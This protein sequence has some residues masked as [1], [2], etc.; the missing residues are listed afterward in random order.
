MKKFL[1]IIIVLFVLVI[2]LYG[3]WLCLDSNVKCRLLYGKNICNFYAMTDIATSN[4]TT[5]DFDKMIDLCRDM[6]DVPKK[7]GCFDF[8][9]QTFAQIDINKAKEAC[10]YIKGFDNV[11]TKNNCYDMIYNKTQNN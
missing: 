4:S 10:D 7:D 8:I 6:T 11:H 2:G 5:S 1:R 3:I 9:A